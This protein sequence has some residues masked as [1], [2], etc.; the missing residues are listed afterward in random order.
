MW[1]KKMLLHCWWEGTVVY[2]LWTT[3][4]RFLKEIKTRK[5]LW[6]SNATTLGIYPK[7]TNTNL[8]GIFCILLILADS[9][10][11][12]YH[13]IIFKTWFSLVTPDSSPGTFLSFEFTVSKFPFSLFCFHL[14]LKW[15]YSL[16][17][18]PGFSSFLN[19]YSPWVI[20]TWSVYPKLFKFII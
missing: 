11:N 2:L 18:C 9:D 15:W 4:W 19:L 10:L 16:G 8:N 7:K 12:L 13:S 5:T 14:L 6:S 3:V 1:R 17:F 20:T